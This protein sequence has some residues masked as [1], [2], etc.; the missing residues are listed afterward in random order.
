VQYKLIRERTGKGAVFSKKSYAGVLVLL[1]VLS[2]AAV[3]VF[4]PA[5]ADGATNLPAAVGNEIKLTED[6][7]LS[8]DFI[9]PT[10]ITLRDDGFS[11]TIPAGV[12]LT[13]QGAFIS[14]GSPYGGEETDPKGIFG[15]I[16]VGN[17]GNVEFNGDSYNLDGEIQI[18]AGGSATIGA[19][20]EVKVIGTENSKIIV[21][22]NLNIGTPAVEER[23]VSSTLVAGSVDVIGSG[24]LSSAKASGLVV[25]GI[26]TIGEA[27]TAVP[28][29]I[30]ARVSGN[31]TLVDSA[32]LLAYGDNPGLRDQ[33]TTETKITD[34]KIMNSEVSN[35][36]LYAVQYQYVRSS[37]LI[38]K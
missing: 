17:G 5:S 1:A 4:V 8:Y 13:V 22:G 33:F 29:T 32:Y 20:N 12:T 10:G 19:H 37:E 6:T 25:L 7:R 28:A 9:V 18:K 14:T 27:P 15:S 38:F 30:N 35:N 36:T 11:L 31:I 26:A 21:E 24:S 23:T 16:I 3:L 2:L 34:F